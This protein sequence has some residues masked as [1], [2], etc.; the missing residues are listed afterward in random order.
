MSKINN[1]GSKR[2]A[3]SRQ[4]EQKPKKPIRAPY[5]KEPEQFEKFRQAAWNT[6]VISTEAQFARMVRMVTMTGATFC[7]MDKASS[8]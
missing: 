5:A 6:G 4:I 1:K 3:M 7:R 8:R 2:S